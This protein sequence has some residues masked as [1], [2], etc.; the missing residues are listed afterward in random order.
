MLRRLIAGRDLRIVTLSMPNI[1]M[2]VA[3]A[4]AEMRR[5]TLDLLRQIVQLA[6]ALEVP[7]V[8]VG[9]ARATR[10]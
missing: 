2:N 3:A 5:Y 7:G 1:E 6:G 9:S 10:C 8:V 4:C